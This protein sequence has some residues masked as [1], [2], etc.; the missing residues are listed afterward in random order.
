MLKDAP[1]E[2]LIVAVRT[3]AA[4]EALLA[5]SIT[6]RLIEQYVRR[7]G[8]SPT[9]PIASERLT[10]R[11][12]EVLALIGRGSTNGE[13]AAKLVLSEATVKTHVGHIFGKL[14]LRDR[15]QAVVF[16]YENGIVSPG[17]P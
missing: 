8:P 3:I 13:I 14:D 5:P 17:S 16:A 11:E 9:R 7:P 15:A 4:G 1:P 2:Q 12:V 10:S 6:R